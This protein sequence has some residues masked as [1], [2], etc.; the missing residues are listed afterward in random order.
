[1]TQDKECEHAIDRQSLVLVEGELI[2]DVKC[3]HC[4]RSGSVYLAPDDAQWED[5]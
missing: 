3:S 2:V 5:D 4:G 1:M